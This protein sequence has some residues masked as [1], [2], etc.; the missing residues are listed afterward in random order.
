[1]L[2]EELERFIRDTIKS[3][4][5]LELLLLVARERDRPW[6]PADLNRELRGHIRLVADI[7][8]QFE[9]SGLVKLEGDGQYRFAPAT[10]ELASAVDELRAAY[11]DR[12]LT[13]VKTVIAAPDEKIRTF[14][15]AFKIRKD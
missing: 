8:A 10:A 1:L 11:A 15:D 6:T 4:W 5:A 9:R 2:S 12:P 3:L 7:L 13:V 14:A